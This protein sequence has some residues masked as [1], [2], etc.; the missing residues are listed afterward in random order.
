MATHNFISSLAIALSPEARVLSEQSSPE[1]KDSLTRWSEYGIQMPSAVVQPATE[2]DIITAVKELVSASISF[3]PAS[4]GHSPFSTVGKE[5]VIIDL[6]RFTGVEVDEATNFATIKGG[7]LSK[8][9]QTALHRYKRFA[10]MCETQ[11][12]SKV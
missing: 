9:V 7:T 4:G 5:G 10:G 2:N 11:H 8:Q 1:F 6:S 3:V 12:D